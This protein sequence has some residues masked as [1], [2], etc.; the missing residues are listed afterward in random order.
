M[1]VG[2]PL[3]S[4]GY[5]HLWW[6]LESRWGAG[7]TNYPNTQIKFGF[8]VEAEGLLQV[9]YMEVNPWAMNSSILRWGIHDSC[10]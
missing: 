10:G 2:K 5:P 6:W 4:W 8:K 3:G 7:V 1:V 9:L